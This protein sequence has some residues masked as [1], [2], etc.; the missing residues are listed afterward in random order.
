MAYFLFIDESGQ[1]HKQS[2]YEVLAGF[3]IQDVDLWKFIKEVH[4]IETECFGRKYRA[5]EREIKGMKF[6]KRKTFKLAEQMAPIDLFERTE[7][8]K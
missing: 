7:W 5:N 8:A 4:E 3:A 6:L 1:D 2:P